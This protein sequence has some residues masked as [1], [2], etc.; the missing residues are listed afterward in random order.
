V[1][2]TLSLSSSIQ[3][4]SCLV[5]LHRTTPTPTVS[6]A[7]TDATDSGRLRKPEI[8]IA[9]NR[10]WRYR[11]P[12]K[13]GNCVGLL[14]FYSLSSFLPSP[15]FP[16]FDDGRVGLAIKRRQ[17]RLGLTGT[18]SCVGVS[19]STWR[20]QQAWQQAEWRS[21]RGTSRRRMSGRI[22][23]TTSF[24]RSPQPARDLHRHYLTTWTN[25]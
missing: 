24:P 17:G 20:R 2:D 21:W 4:R 19:V 3:P 5:R 1:V 12:P 14:R 18:G 23:H 9:E 10:K 7:A 25:K 15:F 8:E 13:T 11:S 6:A 22:C 16:H